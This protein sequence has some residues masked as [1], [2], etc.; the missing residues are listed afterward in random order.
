MIV[1]KLGAIAPVV[2]LA[3]TVTVFMAVPA[4]MQHV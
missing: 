2:L 3:L 1:C 4:E